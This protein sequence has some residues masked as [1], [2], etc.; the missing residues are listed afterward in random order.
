MQIKDALFQNIFKPVLFIGLLSPT[1][2]LIYGLWSNLLGA[3]PIETI[4]HTLGEWALRILILTLLISPLRRFFNW[5]QI[6]Q[7]RRMM[8]LYV[9][10]YATLHVT[11]Y[12]WFEQGFDLWSVFQDILERPFITAGVVAFLLLTPMAAT[13]SRLRMQQLGPR[14]KWIHMLVYPAVILAVLHF[15]WLVKADTTEP[16]IYAIFAGG[17]LVERLWQMTKK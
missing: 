5:P 14:W 6:L 1:L 4:F 16:L 13:S 15:W 8:G 11:C 9:F 2:W 10:Y 12:L 17:L 3:N 7:V